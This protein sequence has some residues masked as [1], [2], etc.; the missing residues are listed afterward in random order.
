MVSSVSSSHPESDSASESLSDELPATVQGESG[1]SE[2]EREPCPT[3]LE[4][5]EILRVFLEEAEHWYLDVDGERV[6]GR[7]WGSGPTLY[8]LNGLSGTHELYALLVWLLREDFRCVVFDY[9]D[10]SSVTIPALT[11]LLPRVVEL[12]GHDQ[13]VS[14]YTRDF[15]SQIARW[16]AETH[17]GLIGSLICQTPILGLPLK[18]TE[19]RLAALARHLPLRARRIPGRVM[20]QPR[21]HRIW[22]P[23]YDQS[24]F[25]FY[26][27]NSGQQSISGLSQRFLLCGDP[28]PDWNLETAPEN[29]L[30][31]RTEGEGAAQASAAECLAST[32]SHSQ[33]EWMHT[34]GQLACL[35]HPHRVAKLV[36]DFLK[37]SE[38]DV[39]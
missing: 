36:R 17:H 23:P 27:E 11:E 29:L 39:S 15:G 18:G 31:I 13:P 24:R 3:P 9:P 20:V 2:E 6:L 28:I 14:V 22:F 30:V 5:H 19:R 7:T 26:L 38:S 34:S 25:D 8:F 33:T 10:S 37:P 12:H 32:L 35:T 4:W 21:S 1:P 16:T